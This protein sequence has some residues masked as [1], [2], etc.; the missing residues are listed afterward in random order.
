MRDFPVLRQVF[1]GLS[2]SALA[3]VP[4]SAAPAASADTAAST[5]VR[6]GRPTTIT[7]SDRRTTITGTLVDTGSGAALGGEPLHLTMY[8]ADRTTALADLGDVTTAADGTFGLTTAVPGPGE[9][10]ATFAGDDTHAR[11]V[12]QTAVVVDSRLPGRVLLDPPP[13]TVDPDTDFTISG[14]AQEQTPD[15]SWEPANWAQVHLSSSNAYVYV[16]QDGRF[17]FTTRESAPA[18]WTVYLESDLSSF[19]AAATSPTEFVDVPAWQTRVASLIVHSNGVAQKGLQITVHA[20]AQTG[21]RWAPYTGK[22]D[23]YFRPKGS[24]DWRAMTTDPSAPS[25][26]ANGDYAFSDVVCPTRHIP[27]ADGKGLQSLVCEDGSWQA[28]VERVTSAP[29]RTAVSPSTG[30]E[31]PTVP[32]KYATA[33][34]NKKIV[35]SGRSRYLH[36]TLWEPL[37]QDPGGYIGMVP[38][39]PVKLYY[40]YRGGKVWHYVTTTTADGDGRLSVKLTGT[41]RYYRLVYGGSTLYAGTTSG[42]VYFSS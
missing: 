27:S 39:Q 9:L 37:G 40:R 35:S 42:R 21:G 34:V 23:L 14:Q 28:G 36:A 41:H 1:A 10:R 15:G 32:Q 11:G 7:Y 17:S 8:A 29:G 38:H 2:A 12:G 22:L 13:A 31:V 18:D 33:V 3:T 19:A 4:L 16:G 25:V 30:D 24:A 5:T 20:D 6:L 26:N